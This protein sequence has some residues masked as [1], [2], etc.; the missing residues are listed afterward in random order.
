MNHKCLKRRTRK[1]SLEELI[2]I[3]LNSILFLITCLWTWLSSG[4]SITTSPII[5][6]WQPNRRPCFKPRFSWYRSSTSF[7]QDNE[8]ILESIPNLVKLPNDGWVY[9][10]KAG[11]RILIV[12]I[13][14]R[15]SPVDAQNAVESLCNTVF[16]SIFWA[17]KMKYILNI[18]L[19][20]KIY[21]TFSY[22]YII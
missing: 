8:E 5:F 16:K 15:Y 22:S 14:G 13:D 1:L 12:L 7:W 21:K 4:T 20:Y 9:G 19:L 11:D 2:F 10:K 6:V 17:W 18:S 3:S